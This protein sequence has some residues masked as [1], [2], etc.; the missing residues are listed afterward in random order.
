MR[1]LGLTTTIPIAGDASTGE[2]DYLGL[3]NPV[4][5]QTGTTTPDVVV[6]EDG[7]F[8][9]A[10]PLVAGSAIA[11]V[12]VEDALGYWIEGPVTIVGDGTSVVVDP[13]PAVE[14]A[15]IGMNLA[16]I[17]GYNGN[18][19]FANVLANLYPWS[20]RATNGGSGAWSQNKGSVTANVS[21]DEFAAVLLNP[22]ISRL[23]WTNGTY[24]VF[25]P[26]GCQIA[27]GYGADSPGSYN[28]A[29]QFDISL[30]PTGQ[31]GVYMFVKGS[32]TG[33]VKVVQPGYYDSAGE[34]STFTSVITTFY[35]NLILGP[36]R[37]M[38]WTMASQNYEVEWADRVTPDHI[39][40]SNAFTRRSPCVPWEYC[41]DLANLLNRDAWIC[42]SP[43]ASQDYINQLAA[44]FAARLNSNLKVWIE[45]GNEI[46]N[47]GSPWVDGRQWVRYLHHT[48]KYAVANGVANTFTYPNHGF[49]E[50]DRIVCFSTAEN[51]NLGI[52]FDD[53]GGMQYSWVNNIG[54][55][56]YVHVIDAD[57]FSL[58]H[59]SDKTIPIPVY[60]NQV[61]LLFIKRDESGKEVNTEK[62][63]AELALR[64]WDAFD[65]AMGPGRVQR[66]ICGQAG[67]SW[68]NQTELAYLDTLSPGGQARTSATASAPYF[69]GHVY[70][71]RIAKTSGTFTPTVWCSVTGGYFIVAVY[72]AGANPTMQEVIAGTGAINWQQSSSYTN[73]ANWTASGLAAITG[74]TN[75]TTYKVYVIGFEYS[76]VPWM[77]SASI[78]AA[79]SGTDFVYD[80]YAQQALRMSRNA[81]KTNPTSN[82]TVSGSIPHISYELGADFNFKGPPEAKTWRDS[83]MESSECGAAL[84]QCMHIRAAG[85]VKMLSYFSDCGSG[86]F[87][88]ATNYADTSDARYVAMKALGGRVAVRTPLTIAN[89]NAP[90]IELDP[91]AYPYTVY[92]MPDAALTYTIISG[93]NTGLFS[94][95]GN[96]LKL[97]SGAGIDWTAP[98]YKTVTLLADDG[99][100]CT[101]FTVSVMLGLNW[102]EGDAKFAWSGITDSDPAA[103]NPTIGGTLALAGTAA[104]VAGGM[105]DMSGAASYSSGSSGSSAGDSPWLVAAVMDRDGDVSGFKSVVQF[106]N[107]SRFIT[108]YT[109]GGGA[110][111]FVARFYQ[112]TPNDVKFAASAPTGKHVFWAFWDGTMVRAGYDQVENISGAVARGNFNS[113]IT[114]YVKIG[115]NTQMKVGAVQSVPRAG[116][117]ITDALAIVAKMQAHHSIP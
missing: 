36:L 14:Y 106:G 56:P 47:P 5:T 63:Y 30:S 108:F 6:A 89:I 97:T 112:G 70:G 109:G 44:L 46:W 9:L 11:N 81:S 96:V 102:Y 7:S 25:N 39:S 19:P 99:Y 101:E 98:S 65:N 12:H 16:S 10:N 54:A 42:I 83:F 116:M 110:A 1:R 90:K 88:L 38:D 60:D 117:T 75:G 62:F 4:V 76:T 24:R 68:V 17:N 59:P 23:G 41:I 13:G 104:S 82:I 48:R 111:N 34:T 69:N 21:T 37:F 57:T 8:T 28:S 15:N 35:N 3:T 51:L 40:F 50:E 86:P 93:N 45:V 53:T 114:Q 115:D 105:W 32:L 72:A 80:S 33:K 27:F 66:L 79:A 49:A 18:F 107:S 77:F 26:D 29:T 74:L 43:R 71:A 20:R 92:T 87:S 58:R 78:V 103:I 55:E 2:I 22:N 73:S 95:T 31:Q 94:L 85:G 67:N 113:G 64:Q 84:V 52:P 61:N 100:L 91:G